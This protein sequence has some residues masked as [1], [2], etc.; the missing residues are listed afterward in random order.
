MPG[1]AVGSVVQ[2]KSGGAAM[3]VTFC[4]EKEVACKWLTE[5]GNPMR[6]SFPVEA[7][8]PVQL[9]APAEPPEPPGPPVLVRLVEG[10]K[11]EIARGE[12]AELQPMGAG[13]EKV[14]RLRV[15]GTASTQGVQHLVELVLARVQKAGVQ[16]GPWQ[17]DGLF[18][19]WKIDPE[20]A[21]LV[22]VQSI[23]E[24]MQKLA[25]M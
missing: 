6:D 15:A 24:G 13:E 12:V 2:L 7:V 18:S 9:T 20:P 11:V 25:G 10:Q 1:Y 16:P 17:V 4:D 3:T 19:S 22:L 14:E 21:S 5:G 23:L 8:Q